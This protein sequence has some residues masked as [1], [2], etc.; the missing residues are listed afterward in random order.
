MK[1]INCEEIIYDFLVRNKCDGLCS[2][3]G[4][5]SCFLNDLFPCGETQQ[6]C[7]AGTKCKVRCEDGIVDGIKVKKFANTKLRAKKY[8]KV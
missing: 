6:N 4:E 8:E 2:E 5:C 1:T 3:W 7:I